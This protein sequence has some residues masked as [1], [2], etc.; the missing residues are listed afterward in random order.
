MLVEELA[1]R[2]VEL[3]PG[4]TRPNLPAGEIERLA[5]EPVVADELLRRLAET[6]GPRHVGIA[7]GLGVSRVEVGHDRLAWHDGTVARLV[8]NRGLSAVRGD[9]DVGDDHPVLEE[10]AVG[11]VSQALARD[12]A[13]LPQAL[14][15]RIHRSFR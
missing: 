7:A 4:D 11:L 13:P 14:A 15:D 8:P 5:A 1:D 6:K 3:L 2:P 9:D 12:L 10:S